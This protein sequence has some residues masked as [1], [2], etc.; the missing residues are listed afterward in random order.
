MFRCKKTP[1][2]PSR[3]IKFQKPNQFQFMPASQKSPATPTADAPIRPPEFS[4]G[5][6]YSIHCCPKCFLPFLY[7]QMTNTC[8]LG[9]RANQAIFKNRA[10]FGF[11]QISMSTK[12]VAK[13]SV[14][15]V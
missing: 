13:E 11:S 14:N 5:S 6:P 12:T 7:S 1:I 15:D 10:L 9:G 8:S 2:C 3:S 4:I